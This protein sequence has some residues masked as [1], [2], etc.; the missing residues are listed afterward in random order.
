VNQEHIHKMTGAQTSNV[1]SAFDRRQRRNKSNYGADQTDWA[2]VL[3][4]AETGC[5]LL[6][7]STEEGWW[8][9]SV[10]LVLNHDEE[11]STGVILNRP[12][13]ALLHRVVP[14]IDYDA[15]HHKVLS[16]RRVSMGGPMG[17]EK[18]SRCLVALSRQPLEGATSEVFPGL[19]HVSD[20]AAVTQEHEKH[21]SVFVGYCGWV[22]GQLDAEVKN[23]GWLVAAASASNTLGLVSTAPGA[24]LMGENAWETLRT[25][26]GETSGDAPHHK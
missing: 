26:L 11:G 25:R 9:H 22:E 21:L 16:D 3:P 20:F 7:P 6:A 8:R 15:P 4:T 13:N 10:V 12:T 1:V 23:G 18:G 24:D 14:E 17:T 19:W 2:H 5:L